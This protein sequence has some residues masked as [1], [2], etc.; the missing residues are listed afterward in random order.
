[1]HQIGWLVT[2]SCG[3]HD[4]I[5]SRFFTVL[6][7]VG[8]DTELAQRPTATRDGLTPDEVIPAVA[9]LRTAPVRTPTE[10]VAVRHLGGDW[11]DLQQDVEGWHV[12]EVNQGGPI[13][14]QLPFNAEAYRA[15]QEVQGRRRS[16]PLGSSFDTN[17]SIFYWQPDSA[18]LG[19]F[20]LVF[21]TRG[22]DAVRLRVVVK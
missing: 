2:D 16:L 17:A 18:F 4:G 14:V 3:Q 11:E 12:V 20:D 22:G 19:S 10:R 6:N 7:G 15:F 8:G 13:E 1:M 5:G 21:D 9:Q